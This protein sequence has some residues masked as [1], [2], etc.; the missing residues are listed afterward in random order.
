ML[1]LVLS[2][3]ILWNTT[4]TQDVLEA[5]RTTGKEVLAPDVARLSPYRLCAIFGG[6]ETYFSFVVSAYECV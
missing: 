6:A 2:A 3:V 4:Y 1:G 5:L